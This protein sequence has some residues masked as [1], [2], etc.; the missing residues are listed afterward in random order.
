MK[1]TTLTLTPAQRKNTWK[2]MQAGVLAV[3]FVKTSARVKGK[4]ASAFQVCVKLDGGI[5]NFG[6]KHSSLD[7]MNAWASTTR[8]DKPAE[9][10]DKF[11]KVA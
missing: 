6:P 1:A 11:E 8:L 3:R 7:S 5:V 10:K 4:F 2:R 9:I